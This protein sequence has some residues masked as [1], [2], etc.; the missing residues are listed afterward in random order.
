MSDKIEEYRRRNEGVRS[1]GAEPDA[2]SPSAM[3]G[4]GRDTEIEVGG[5]PAEL[6]DVPDAAGEESFAVDAS[7]AAR[8]ARLLEGIDPDIAKLISDEE[9]NQIEAEER[10]EAEAMRKDRALKDVRAALRQKARIEHD[11]ISADRL[12]T[13]A[14]KKR[15]A[16]PITF[17]INV[18]VESGMP[19]RGRNGICVDGFLYEEGKT[20]TR[21]RAV[22]DSL[23][24]TIYRAHMNEVIFTSLNQ[25]KRGNTAE[26]IIS[27]NPPIIQVAA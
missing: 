16:E 8:R 6:P 21:P 9:L 10:A 1:R 22:Y 24:Y 19:A 26:E 12:R 11:L 4:S 2:V 7:A 25:D 3:E 15:L 18:P 13:D 5:E 14:E 23:R 20:Y 17:V 27:R